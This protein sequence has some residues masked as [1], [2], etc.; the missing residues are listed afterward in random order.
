MKKSYKIAYLFAL[1]VSVSGFSQEEIVDNREIARS[2]E[3]CPRPGDCQGACSSLITA[4]TIR[5][6]AITMSTRK[7]QMMAS[8]SRKAAAAAA[9]A[10]EKALRSTRKNR[11]QSGGFSFGCGV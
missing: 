6:I 5:T 11:S 7:A 1:V 8:A 2:E 3:A 4:D 9:N 10:V